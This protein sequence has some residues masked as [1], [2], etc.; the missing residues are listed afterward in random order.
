[1]F[2]RARKEKA[3]KF[4]ELLE[5][6]RCQLV[7]VVGMEIGGQWSSE[8]ANFVDML[9]QAKAPEG[10]VIPLVVETQVDAHVVMCSRGDLVGLL[11]GRLAAAQTALIWLTCSKLDLA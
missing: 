1:M 7:V 8:A 3:A 5:G 9:A 2:H 10:A 4:S 11:R 6:G